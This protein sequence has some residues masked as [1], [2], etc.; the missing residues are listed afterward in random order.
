MKK[1]TIIITSVLLMASSTVF[2][3]T[4]A[5][6]TAAECDAIFATADVN[7][8]G[9]IDGMEMKTM[10]AGMLSMMMPAESAAG[11]ST[12]DTTATGTPSTENP[13]ANAAT[14]QV[15]GDMKK[16]VPA[17]SGSAAAEPVPGTSTSD[18]TATGTAS[19]ENPDANAATGQAAGE[20][21]KEVPATSGSAAAEPV[22][23]TSTSDT[24]ATGTPT[25][26]NPDAN[27][28]A[29]MNKEAFLAACTKG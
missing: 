20:M 27:A 24:T 11:T 16:E 4:A 21:N 17:T 7:T 26:E 3:Q 28:A 6:K 25:T 8:D 12:S 1:S 2:A 23:G 18:T 29:N 19:T 5:T 14:G 13:D 22:P 10:D 15:A 9:M